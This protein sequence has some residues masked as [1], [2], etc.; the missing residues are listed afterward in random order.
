VVEAF[1]A[2]EWQ[3]LGALLGR[4]IEALDPKRIG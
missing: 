1:L 3:T 2:D 4:W